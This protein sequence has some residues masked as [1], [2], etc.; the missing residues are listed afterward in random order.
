M[1]G[2]VPTIHALLAA[3]IKKDVDAGARPGMTAQSQDADFIGCI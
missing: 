3:P 1:A 2:L